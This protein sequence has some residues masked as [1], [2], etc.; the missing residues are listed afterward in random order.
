MKG[1]FLKVFL[2]LGLL[3]SIF[4]P[5]SSGTTVNAT[6][7]R[8]GPITPK[9]TIYQIVTDRFYDGDIS[10][11]IPQGFDPTLFDGSGSDLKLY[12]G[13]DFQGI[14]DKIPYLK[15]MG[16]TAVWISAPYSNRDTE[17][18]DYQ[19]DGSVDRWTSFHGYHASNYFTTNKHFGTMNDFLNMKDALQDNG[20]KVV[21]D[22]VANHTSRWQ[23]PT[24]NFSPEDGKLYEPSKDQ[25]GNYVF[26]SNGE[27]VD[28]NG[29]GKKEYLVADPNNDINDWFYKIGDRGS[30][31]SRYGFRYKDL[32]SLASFNHENPDVIEHL[33]KA[34][35]FWKAKG[36]DGIRHD[37]TLHMNPAFVKGFKQYID[38][39]PG[40]PITHFGEF[41]I[42]R[43][44]PKYAEYASFPDRTG[45]NNLDFE[46][47]RTSANAFG[48]FSESMSNFGEM[49][50][51]TSSDYTYE[52]QAIT[53][54]DNHDVT[55]FRYI[56]QN[57]KPY[58]AG[59]VALMTSR[60][61]PNIYYGTEQYLT[62]SDASDIAG[63][64]F[65]QRETEFDQSTTAYRVI[66]LLS[67]LR[68]SNE[69]V[70]YGLTEVLH[71]D[72][73]SI[74]YKRTFFDKSVIVA[75]N[76]HPDQSFNIPSLF[77]NLPNGTYSD[78]LG[79]LLNGKDLNVNNGYSN[80]FT[81]SGGEVAVWSYN[82]NLGDSPKIGDVVSTSGKA[83]DKVY[84]YGTGLSG[85]VS[86][87][88]GGVNAPV[89]MNSDDLL[90]TIVPSGITGEVDITIRKNNQTSNAFTYTILSGDQ[91]QIVFNINENTN[92]GETIHIVGNVPELGSW[93]P[94]KSTEALLNPEHPYWFLP[95]SLPINRTIEY[96]FIKKNAQG[97]VTWESGNNRMINTPTETNG[98]S[99]T[100]VLYWRH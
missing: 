89:I 80:T 15:E 60:G 61:T 54:L 99:F 36:I 75:I 85:D 58:H 87:S 55:R 57:D 82:P 78:V 19:P 95:V 45:V 29:D 67:D 50:L 72:L 2:I 70:A 22:F 71:S 31:D 4:L 20:I 9:D 1:R 30:D 74:V 48:N 33:Y 24:A 52:N 17:I 73:H 8:L 35:A 37:A 3:I 10:N 94:D 51:K 32:G 86:V 11:N 41:F 38:S 13:G 27:P 14:V 28:L 25:F 44:D 90:T 62:S 47:F 18:L 23:N 92:Y 59:I 53:F 63:R 7:D 46:F 79:G 96:K 49:L 34:A 12:Q 81:L 91:A 65:M 56:Q 26:D 98:V 64:V 88:F 66:K 100:P 39:A 5:V 6:L 68:K 84:I 76:R 21:I 83:G 43:P 40:G 16:I 77:T 42:G 97:V 69:A 93:D